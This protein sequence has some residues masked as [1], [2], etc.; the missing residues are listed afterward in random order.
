MPPSR[1]TSRRSCWRV[2]AAP[3]RAALTAASDPEL[4]ADLPH[5]QV[6]GRQARGAGALL[7]GEGEERIERGAVLLDPVGPEV[8]PEDLLRA[9]RVRGTPGDRVIRR[10]AVDRAGE[11]AALGL[12]KRGVQVHRRPGVALEHIAAQGDDVH[13]REDPGLAVVL[14]LD[15][16]VVAEQP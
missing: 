12:A 6:L 2:T 1:R 16:A 8:P 13:D 7:I 11:A 10:V 15:R 14:L 3:A 9:L 4:L 5:E